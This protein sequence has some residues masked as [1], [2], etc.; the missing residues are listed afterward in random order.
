MLFVENA[1]DKVEYDYHNESI[2]AF[3][4]LSEHFDVHFYL[5]DYHAVTNSTVEEMEDEFRTNGINV[6]HLHYINA[7]PSDFSEAIFEQDV[8]GQAGPMVLFEEM[9]RLGIPQ[10]NLKTDDNV[11]ILSNFIHSRAFIEAYKSVL[12][13][14]DSP[15]TLESTVNIINSLS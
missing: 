4:V 11:V 12:V 15:L 9:V 1:T 13:K 5:A 8:T 14:I 2:T 6:G 7:A 3:N 10:F